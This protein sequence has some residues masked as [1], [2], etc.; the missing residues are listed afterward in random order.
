ML[1]IDS[2]TDEHSGN[3]TCVAQNKAGTA[4][5]SADLNVNGTVTCEC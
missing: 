5:Y 2:V 3:Y 4:R 1:T